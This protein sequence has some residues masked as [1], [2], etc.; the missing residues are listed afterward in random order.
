MQKYIEAGIQVHL[1]SNLGRLR[2][3]HGDTPQRRL[4]VSDA[5]LLMVINCGECCITL[6]DSYSKSCIIMA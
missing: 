3:F 5:L 6:V 4:T 2:V 1:Q